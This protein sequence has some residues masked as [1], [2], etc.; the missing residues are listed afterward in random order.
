MTDFNFKIPF[1]FEELINI[2]DDVDRYVV[3]Q[4]YSF[5]EVTQFIEGNYK[6]SNFFINQFLVYVKTN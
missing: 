2:N 3:S 1:K 6:C 4:E 5:S